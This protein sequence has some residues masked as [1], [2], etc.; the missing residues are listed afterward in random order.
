MRR[1]FMFWLSKHVAR[2]FAQGYVFPL[3]QKGLQWTLA[4]LDED[5]ERY[6]NPYVHQLAKAGVVL[7]AD[8]Q[9]TGCK[10]GKC[11]ECGRSAGVATIGAKVFCANCDVLN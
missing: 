11:V 8:E 7:L 1:R 5:V 6:G 4:L 3:E 10:P 2:H 9:C